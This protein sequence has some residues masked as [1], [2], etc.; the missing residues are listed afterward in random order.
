[1]KSVFSREYEIFRRCIIAARKEARLT[2]ATLAGYLQKP[3]SFVSK[4]ESGER[5]LDIVEFLLVTRAIGVDPCDIVREVE[6]AI[7]RNSCEDRA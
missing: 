5:R 2:Q 1:M 6:R 4:Y 7:D 3:Q